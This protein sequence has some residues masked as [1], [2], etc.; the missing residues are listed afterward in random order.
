M[1][2]KIIDGSYGGDTPHVTPLELADTN[3]S[4]FGHENYV[5]PVGKQFSHTL[6]TNSIEISDGQLMMQGIRGGIT[7]NTTKVLTFENGI[8][9]AKR[10][11]LVVARYAKNV[12][13]NPPI[14]TMDLFVIK[15]DNNQG[16][17]EYK[18]SVIRDG[19]ILNEYPIKRVRFEG[20]NIVAV[21]NLYTPKSFIEMASPESGITGNLLAS[22]SITTTKIADEA[23]TAKKI[24][25]DAIYAEHLT[26]ESVEKSALSGQIHNHMRELEEFSHGIYRIMVN[27]F[28]KRPPT[29]PMW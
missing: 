3:M 28:G 9:G 11:D 26:Y 15:G 23:V 5:L 27:D 1:S 17:P 7:A 18:T 2:F 16:D 12:Q 8:V 22:G 29:P 25:Q 13:V 10:N 4:I 24:A 20:I 6:Q 21:D 14:D 19:G